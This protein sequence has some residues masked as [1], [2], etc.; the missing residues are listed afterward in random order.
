MYWLQQRA[1][2]EKTL[3]CYS[4]IFAE[5]LEATWVC[6]GREGV[7]LERGGEELLQDKNPAEQPRWAIAAMLVR[8]QNIFHCPD[9]FFSIQKE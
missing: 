1:V 7:C 3:S 5:L 2:G 6:L 9:N 4:E 8:E